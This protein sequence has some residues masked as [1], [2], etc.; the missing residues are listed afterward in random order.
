MHLYLLR[1]WQ[2]EAGTNAP[3]TEHGTVQANRLGDV[4]ASVVP[5]GDFVRI[6]TSDLHRAAQTA[7]ILRIKLGVSEKPTRLTCFRSLAR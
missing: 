3:L 7:N 4:L 6:L 5:D 1:H 2:P